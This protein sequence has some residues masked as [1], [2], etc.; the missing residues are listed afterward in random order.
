MEVSNKAIAVLLVAALA[1]YL[2]GT[3]LSLNRL[4]TLL[5]PPPSGLVTSPPALGNV[6]LRIATQ[7]AI[8]WQSSTIEWGSGYVDGSCNNCTMHVNTSSNRVGAAND[9]FDRTCCIDFNWSN[10]SLLLKNTGNQIVSLQFNVTN[11]HTNW[12]G[13]E[14]LPGGFLMKIVPVAF[15]SHYLNG[16]G[17]DT[18][19][20]N[21]CAG[22]NVGNSSWGGFLAGTGNE[23]LDAWVT[24]GDWTT[25]GTPKYIC[26]SASNFNFTFAG[27]A[28]EAN[29]DF[30]VTIP[31]NYSSTGTFSSIIYVLATS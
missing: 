24:L 17:S 25:N 8:A 28:N 23:T 1:V 4:G 27:G 16:T 9:G 10:E 15:R 11:N 31:Q 22:L 19:T 7:T 6:T 12:F 26:G 29:F 18:D 2:G 3:V 21:S 14:A 30:R 13:T 5:Q 20:L